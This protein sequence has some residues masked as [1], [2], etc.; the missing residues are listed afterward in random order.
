M[1]KKVIF[2]TERLFLKSVKIEDAHFIL[3]LYNS[4]KFLQ[5]VGDRNIKVV[6][7][8]EKHIREKFLPH[9]ET[10]GFGS[11]IIVRKSDSKKVG[12]VGIYKRDGL[13]A[14]DIGFSLLPEF[15]RQGYGFE[16]SK[17]LLKSGFHE[18]GLTKISAITIKENIGSQ[19]LIEKLGLQFKSIIQLP[20]YHEEL[21]YYEIEKP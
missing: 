10:H 9:Y 3:E 4:P 1:Q 11:Y 16:G 8:A 2:E 15:E 18:F 14:P 13:A 12:N 7:D 19:K 17:R 20:D 5:F 21:M 6:E